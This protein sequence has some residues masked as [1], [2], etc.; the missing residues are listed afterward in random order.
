M[1]QLNENVFLTKSDQKHA[2]LYTN[3]FKN[4]ETFETSEETTV[5]EKCEKTKSGYNVVC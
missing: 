3:F 5:G 1:F 4:I 2:K